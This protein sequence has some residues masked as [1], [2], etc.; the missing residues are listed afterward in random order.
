MVTRTTT[1]VI[2]LIVLACSVPAARAVSPLYFGT[3]ANGEGL[4][5][6]NPEWWSG[7]TLTNPLATS[8]Q[9]DTFID[10][11]GS[12]SFAAAGNFKIQP[13][14][15]LAGPSSGASLSEP[16]LFAEGFNDSIY[17]WPAGNVTVT[18]PNYGTSDVE[19]DTVVTLQIATTLGSSNG[20]TV[21]YAIVPGSFA[22]TD[23]SD[24]LI[25]G[26]LVGTSSQLAEPHY[27]YDFVPGSPVYG[28]QYLYTFTI[29]AW[30]GDFKINWMQNDHS[31]LDAVRVDTL[32]PEPTALSLLG[33]AGWALIC[34]RCRKSVNDA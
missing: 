22:V 27:A 5:F 29:P 18:I 34:R 16:S 8:Q 10:S 13:G 31:V 20:S 4:K 7:P 33:V 3:P 26:A 25:P 32:V 19:G 28:V 17:F 2:T 15:K 11:D 24:N 6:Q 9:W 12:A 1:A 30:T 23:L 14:V 21:D